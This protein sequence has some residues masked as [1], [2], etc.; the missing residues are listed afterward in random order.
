M[1]VNSKLSVK[2]AEISAVIIRAD[3]TRED[4]GV[5]SYWHRNPLMRIGWRILR[6][7]KHLIKAA[8]AAFLFGARLWQR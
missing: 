4:V 7:C 2:S 8:K 1:I 6:S 5:I 3:G